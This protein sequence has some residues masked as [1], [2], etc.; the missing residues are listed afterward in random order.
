[1]K[2]A[3]ARLSPPTLAQVAAEAA[4]DT[5]DTYF[6]DV[7]VSYRQRRDALVEGLSSIEGVLCPS[8]GGAVACVRAGLASYPGR[9]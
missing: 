4:L 8:P 7:R 2:F 1:M 9:K 3:M 6:D 5:P